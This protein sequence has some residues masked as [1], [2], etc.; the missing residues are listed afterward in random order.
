MWGG[1][2]GM[3]GSARAVAPPFVYARVVA[4]SAWC[5]RSYSTQHVP[6][7]LHRKDEGTGL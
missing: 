7:A 4:T 3:A 6:P 5:M 2:A 1:G